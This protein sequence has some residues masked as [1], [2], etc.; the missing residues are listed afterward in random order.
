MMAQVQLFLLWF[1]AVGCA[2]IG[3]VYFAFST[4]VMP[5][6][7]RLGHIP[8]MQAMQSINEVILRS[9][10]M[11][12]FFGTTLA[13]LILA[14]LALMNWSASEPNE[15]RLIVLASVLYVGGMF[16]VTVLFNVPLNNALVSVQASSADSG[17]VWSRYLKDWT[18]WNHVRT[19]AS[20]VASVIYIVVLVRR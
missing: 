14:A 17:P 20:I 15:S 1:S 8:G 5:A 9:L 3:G 12:L 10:F 13:S 18:L 2:V 4:F 6:L 11:P 7:A 16:L 19:V